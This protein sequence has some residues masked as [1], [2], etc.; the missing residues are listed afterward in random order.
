[1]PNSEYGTDA[2]PPVGQY[3]IMLSLLLHAEMSISLRKSLQCPQH[4]QPVRIAV[5]F[6][7]FGLR[8]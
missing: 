1:M 6:H 2:Q 8:A 4:L 3:A 7:G 5:G